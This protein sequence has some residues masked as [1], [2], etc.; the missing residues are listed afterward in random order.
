MAK[1]FRLRIHHQRPGPKCSKAKASERRAIGTK[2]RRTTPNRTSDSEK[3]KKDHSPWSKPGE[4]H[5]RELGGS[6]PPGKISAKNWQHPRRSSGRLSI[7]V[8]C[9][10]RLRTRL[11]KRE[12]NSM[13]LYIGNLS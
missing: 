1:E 13:R 10:M 12:T 9:S 4:K 11:A 3:E 2:K 6:P 7:P 8:G 5:G